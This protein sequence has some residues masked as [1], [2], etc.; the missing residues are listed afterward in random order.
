MLPVN[1][2]EDIKPLSDFRAGLSACIQQVNTTKRP[3]VITQHGKGVAVLIDIKEFEAMQARIDLLDELYKAET[4][5]AEGFG[6][7]HNQAK[8]MIMSGL[9]A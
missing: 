3:M 1:I 2:N 4:Q 6:V 5:V 8:K 9:N 7:E